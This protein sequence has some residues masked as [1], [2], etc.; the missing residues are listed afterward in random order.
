M[1][2]YYDL[3][4]PEV[5]WNVQMKLH[6]MTVMWHFTVTLQSWEALHHLETASAACATRDAHV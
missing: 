5:S 4:L 1:I 3:L 2:I 6:V